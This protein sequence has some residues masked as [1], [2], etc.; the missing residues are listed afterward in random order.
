MILLSLSV[1]PP[2]PPVPPHQDTPGILSIPDART[3]GTGDLVNTGRK[4]FRTGEDI[5]KPD[6]IKDYNK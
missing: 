6:V 2:V 4:D 3:S 5:L 1:L